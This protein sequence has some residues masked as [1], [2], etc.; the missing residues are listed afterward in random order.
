MESLCLRCVLGAPWDARLA[1]ARRKCLS[2]WLCEHLVQEGAT[3]SIPCSIED[4]KAGQPAL[5]PALRHPCSTVP[6][7]LTVIALAGMRMDSVGRP[8]G[9]VDRRLAGSKLPAGCP[10]P[11]LPIK[12][13]VLPLGPTPGEGSPAALLLASHCCTA[14]ALC[15]LSPSRSELSSREEA[16]P[17]PGPADASDGARRCMIA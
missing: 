9:R 8:Q 5:C 10:L 12:G 11:Q 14:C 7:A 2:A 13:G 3:A 15:W 16:C 17:G 6:A 1:A 4:T